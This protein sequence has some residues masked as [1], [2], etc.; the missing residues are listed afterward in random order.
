M[1][2]EGAFGC[3]WQERWVK[4]QGAWKKSTTN[5]EKPTNL[6]VSLDNSLIYHGARMGIE[7]NEFEGLT[8]FIQ[9]TYHQITIK[10]IL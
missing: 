5:K 8:E 6:R 1:M 4:S 7:N 9:L 3:I 10:L 2:K